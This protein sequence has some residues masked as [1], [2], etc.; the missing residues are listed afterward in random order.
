VLSSASSARCRAAV[1]SVTPS[2]TAPNSSA[3]IT[4]TAAACAGEAAEVEDLA[5]LLDDVFVASDAVVDDGFELGETAEDGSAALTALVS[6]CIISCS[7]DK[8]DPSWAVELNEALFAVSR[9][10]S[11]LPTAAKQRQLIIAIAARPFADRR[12]PVA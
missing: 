4:L 9:P 1:S 10:Q 3:E 2:P 12:V 5:G 8:I 6:F 7:G 11:R